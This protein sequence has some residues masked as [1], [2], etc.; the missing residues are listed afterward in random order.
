M[1]KQI[2]F[3]FAAI[4][5]FAL[6]S[7]ESTPEKVE[8][9]KNEN[10]SSVQLSKDM[11]QV[12]RSNNKSFQELKQE[13]DEANRIAKEKI[14]YADTEAANVFEELKQEANQANEEAKDKLNYPDAK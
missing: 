14:K 12:P 13:A 5:S 10:E 1:K 7:C 3:V 6:C 9:N 4:F 8:I 11:Y 2:L